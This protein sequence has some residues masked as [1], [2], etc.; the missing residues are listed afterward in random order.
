MVATGKSSEGWTPYWLAVTSVG[1]SLG[2][3]YASVQRFRQMRG[4]LKEYKKRKR[5]NRY[6]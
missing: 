1:L 4:L 3:A 2:I 6:A 5:E